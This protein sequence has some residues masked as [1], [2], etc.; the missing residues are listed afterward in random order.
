MAAIKRLL[1]RNVTGVE[2]FRETRQMAP[3]ILTF[4]VLMS[5][6]WLWDTPIPGGK[7]A[8]VAG[9]GVWFFLLRLLDRLLNNPWPHGAWFAVGFGVLIALVS[10]LPFF[11]VLQAWSLFGGINASLLLLSDFWVKEPSQH[12]EPPRSHGWLKIPY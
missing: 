3:L 2:L 10:R 9:M 7:T 12:E 6:S 8:A 5:P 4:S 1:F 11:Q